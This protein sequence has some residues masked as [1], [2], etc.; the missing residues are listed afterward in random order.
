MADE[1]AAEARW[2]KANAEEQKKVTTGRHLMV[3][4]GAAVKR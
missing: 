4:N 3:T 1:A 2:Q